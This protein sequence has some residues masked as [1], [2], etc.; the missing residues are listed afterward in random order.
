[1]PPREHLNLQ[2]HLQP[3]D[4]HRLLALMSRRTFLEAGLVTAAFLYMEGKVVPPIARSLLKVFVESARAKASP[5]LLAEYPAGTGIRG[6][7]PDNNSMDAAMRV[8]RTLGE[9][10]DSIGFFTNSTG[11]FDNVLPQARLAIAAGKIPMFSWYPQD[12]DGKS[13]R[14]GD[15]KQYESHIRAGARQLKKLGVKVLFRPLYE[16]NGN[17]Y[18]WHDSN[19][20]AEA[21]AFW[22]DIYRIYQEEGATNVVF[23]WSPNVLPTLLSHFNGDAW[24]HEISPFWPGIKTVHAIGLDV[25]ADSGLGLI[26]PEYMIGPNL[27]EA[28]ALAPELPIMLAEVGGDPSFIENAGKYMATHTP[29]FLGV[30][31]FLWG[32]WNLVNDPGR[33]QAVQRLFRSSWFRQKGDPSAQELLAKELARSRPRS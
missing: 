17:W 20:P 10:V 23:V 12:P 2:T 32:D 18:G 29:H 14:Y 7:H 13:S 5:P 16:M 9:S 21:V 8:S 19:S 28:I 24:K 22:Q 30:Y 31:P 4:K 1:M 11:E 25:Y 26:A 27:S 33:A 15:I 6:I 3:E